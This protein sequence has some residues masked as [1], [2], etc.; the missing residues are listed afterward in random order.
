MDNIKKKLQNK[1]LLGMQGSMILLVIWQIFILKLLERGSINTFVATLCIVGILVVVMGALVV[2]VRFFLGK[3]MTIIGGTANEADTVMD[4]KAKKLAER[5]DELGEMARKVQD[6]FSS[7]GKIM[8]GIKTASGELSKVSEHLS[9]IYTSISMAVDKSEVEVKTIQSAQKIR[10]A[11]EIIA[12]IS[13]QT[14]LLALNAS[15]E[16]ARAGDHG[17]GFAVVAEQIRLLADQSKSSTE[18]I[19]AVVDMLLK[20]AD[21]SVGITE[22]VSSAF[23]KQNEKIR[24]TEEILGSLN[25]EVGKV[26]DFISE[27]TDEVQELSVHKDV[28][29]TGVTSLASEANENVESVEIT[30]EN[31]MK[32]HKVV[33]KC[34]AVM[35]DVVG[36]SRELLGYMKEF[37]DMFLNNRKL[38]L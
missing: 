24:E 32:L 30:S 1:V 23:L 4:E 26:G 33:E 6:T 22:E 29:E 9:D 8:E 31:M 38:P 3:I 21:I 17:K 36:V 12:G 5:N 37:G 10:T 11:T 2:E 27:I 16:A 35:G 28:I 7:I 19:G 13:S 20:N 34:D 25:Q 15:I 18:E 14:N